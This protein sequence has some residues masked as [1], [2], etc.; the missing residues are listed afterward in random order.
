M[1]LN[2]KEYLQV[3]DGGGFVVGSK[4]VTYC[5]GDANQ[6]DISTPGFDVT[7][8]TQCNG[9]DGKVLWG[10]STSFDVCDVS[11]NPV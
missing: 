10:K 3:L 9:I 6:P 2:N 8:G 7:A 4:D 5:F 11:V 1:N